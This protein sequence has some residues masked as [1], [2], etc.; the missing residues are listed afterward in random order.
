[1]K[2]FFERSGGLAG[3]SN[4]TMVDTHSLPSDEARKIQGMIDSAKE[5][6]D[7]NTSSSSLPPKRAADYYKYK[8][9]V[10]TEEGKENSIETNDITMP[11]ELK[12][13]IKYLMEKAKQKK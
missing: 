11:S 12:P 9:R 3:I 4:R 10:E 5:F 6:F 2:I 7:S 8:V 13:L 1:M